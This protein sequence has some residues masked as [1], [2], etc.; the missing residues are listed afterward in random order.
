M[1]LPAVMIKIEAYKPLE[2]RHQWLMVTLASFSDRKGRCWPSLRT[3]A[4]KAGRS[5]AWV[6]ENL[7]EMES[8]GYFRR[9]RD[10]GR[11]TYKI[12]RQFLPWDAVSPGR[13][14]VARTNPHDSQAY[15]QGVE[16]ASGEQQTQE[17][18]EDS[19]AGAL[20]GRTTAPPFSRAGEVKG[21]RSERRGRL[22]RISEGWRP[23][24]AE[25]SRA[26][27]RRGWE[28]ERL[29]REIAK[30]AEHYRD[31][32]VDAVRVWRKWWLGAFNEPQRGA[33]NARSDKGRKIVDAISTF[34]D[35]S[36]LARAP[37]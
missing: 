17:I 30:F 8:L 9:A 33:G 6:S 20:G 37:G 28:A 3:I 18:E 12:A 22:E 14:R 13:T 21:G 31:R 24:P 15:A 25:C 19:N 11:Y 26:A 23:D 32:C 10:A 34:L 2:F 35:Q 7:K 1:S 5:L 16:S 36:R 4:A 29:E 27:D